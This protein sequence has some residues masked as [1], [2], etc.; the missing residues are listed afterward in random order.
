MKKT[1]LSPEQLERLQKLAEMPDESIDLNDIPEIPSSAVLYR[2]TKR[3]VTIR[4]DADIVKWFK[5][6]AGDRPYQTEINRVLRQ[7]VVG[8]SRRRA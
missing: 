6:Q 8:A 4:L 1:T 7:H 2:P 3:P 5:D